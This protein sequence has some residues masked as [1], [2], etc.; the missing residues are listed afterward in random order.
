MHDKIVGI[1][2]RNYEIVWHLGMQEI[3]RVRSQV[4]EAKEI[5]NGGRGEYHNPY[6]FSR[7][8]SA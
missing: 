1:V 3:Q 4:A 2:Y 5:D 7:L 8:P 6:S